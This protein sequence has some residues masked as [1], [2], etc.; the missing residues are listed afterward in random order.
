MRRV[1]LPVVLV[2]LVEEYLSGAKMKLVA[3]HY[4]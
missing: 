2:V 4:Y 1:V 3:G